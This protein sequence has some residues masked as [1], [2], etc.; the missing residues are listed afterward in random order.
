M[1]GC[2]A[3]GGIHAQMVRRIERLVLPKIQARV[4][5]FLVRAAYRRLRLG[6]L[7]N[8]LAFVIQRAWRAYK[9]RLVCR[10]ARKVMHIR[11][12][13]DAAAIIFQKVFSCFFYHLSR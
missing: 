6:I 8:T 11:R 4:R 10:K 5:G 3:R 12:N 1:R 2:L 7:Q 13:E 9:V